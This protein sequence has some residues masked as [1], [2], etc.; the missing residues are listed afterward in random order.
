MVIRKVPLIGL[1]NSS[2]LGGVK[3]AGS[4]HHL[5][6]LAQ[7]DPELVTRFFK[8]LLADSFWYFLTVGI[9][10]LAILVF[11]L[12]IFTIKAYRMIVYSLLAIVLATEIVTSIISLNL[13]RPFSFNWDRT[14][15]GGSCY[16]ETVFYE[17]GSFPNIVTDVAILIL[18]MPVVWNLHTSNNM[19]VG[20]TLTFLLASM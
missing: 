2:H 9:P 4:G 5:A 17:W 13:C 6:A 16:Q 1:T 3:Y 18:P 20:L 12:R 10:K 19:K 7:I 8:W 15:P 11:Y 14:I